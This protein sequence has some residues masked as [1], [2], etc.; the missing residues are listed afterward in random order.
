MHV[1]TRYEVP[2]FAAWKAAFEERASVRQEHGCRGE[3]V[4]TRVGSDNRV[5]VLA[6]WDDAD[7]ATG[8]FESSEFKQ[9]MQDAGVGSKPDIT[10]LESIEDIAGVSPNETTASESE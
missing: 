9:A 3:S 7:N 4:Y 8:Y 10:L 2:D 1:L 5:V 6:T